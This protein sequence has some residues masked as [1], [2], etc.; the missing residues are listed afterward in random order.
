MEYLGNPFFEIIK[1][2]VDEYAFP[3][4]SRNLVL[5]NCG[6]GENHVVIG[7]ATLPIDR[8]FQ[9]FE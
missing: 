6:A 7:V 9:N 8:M 3:A 4:F 5:S 1:K 2:T